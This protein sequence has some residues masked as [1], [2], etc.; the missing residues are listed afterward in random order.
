M[1]LIKELFWFVVIM[2]TR[3]FETDEV[4]GNEKWLREKLKEQ[5]DAKTQHRH[6]R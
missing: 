5:G 3:P 2:V 1:K 6:I 4:E